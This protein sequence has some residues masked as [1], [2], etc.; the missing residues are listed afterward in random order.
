MLFFAGKKIEEN[1]EVWANFFKRLTSCI[2]HKNKNKQI[3][4][5]LPLAFGHVIS[6]LVDSNKCIR[7]VEL[8][9]ETSISL[10]PFPDTI[11]Q[12]FIDDPECIYT[13]V[14]LTDNEVLHFIGII[15]TLELIYHHTRILQ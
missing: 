13:L 4:V 14:L 7:T 9:S 2:K 12:R 10:G 6:N 3:C 1:L 15:S 8:I 11:N 5:S